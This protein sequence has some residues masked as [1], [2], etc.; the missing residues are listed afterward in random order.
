MYIHH[1]MMCLQGLKNIIVLTISD[2]VIEF[3]VS[4]G[5]Y[6]FLIIYGFLFA[7]ILCIVVGT[8]VGDWGHIIWTLHQEHAS[9]TFAQVLTVFP[10]PRSKIVWLKRPWIAHKS[11]TW[12][13]KNNFVILDHFEVYPPNLSFPWR[14]EQSMTNKESLWW[15]SS[16]E[17]LT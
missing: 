10:N 17:V 6:A 9:S 12:P 2:R 11:P 3:R 13:S 8:E 5:P 14:E 15:L 7:Q 16:S 4:Q 1:W